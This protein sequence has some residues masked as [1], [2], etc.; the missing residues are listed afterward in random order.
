MEY[1][2][3]ELD[4]IEKFIDSC[5]GTGDVRRKIQYHRDKILEEELK[6]KYLE[7]FVRVEDKTDTSW[8]FIGHVFGISVRHP[9]LSISSKYYI[10]E[11][12]GLCSVSFFNCLTKRLCG[13]IYD[14]FWRY[15]VYVR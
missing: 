10:E 13:K 15:Q 6:E 9:Y 3:E 8:I 11:R 14:K 5:D 7:K 4:F 2:R 1:T 12:R